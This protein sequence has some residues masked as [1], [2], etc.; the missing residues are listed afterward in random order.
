MN[1]FIMNRPELVWFILGLI[2]LLAELVLPGFVIFFFGAGAWIT[3]LVC[4]FGNP[5]INLQ[6]LIFAVTSVLALVIFRKMIQNK[7]IYNK[8][9]RSGEV[10]DEFTGKEAVAVADFGADRMGKVEFKGTSWKAES[11]SEIVAGQRVIIL[12]KESF[13]LIVEPK[14]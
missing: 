10:E 13:K 12:E 11:K 6:V 9:D 8:D 5:G 4:L 3:A 2:L 7:F 1:D 14:K